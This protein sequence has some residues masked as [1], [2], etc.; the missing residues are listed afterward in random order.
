MPYLNK[1]KNRTIDSD[2]WNNEFVTLVKN[3]TL[4]DI[5]ND[6]LSND[7]LTFIELFKR[8]ILNTDNKKYFVTGI[9][10]QGI[11]IYVDVKEYNK[12]R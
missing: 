12:M 1:Y 7:F 8:V 2:V 10:L 11:G 9:E 4:K 6:E 5:S 3:G